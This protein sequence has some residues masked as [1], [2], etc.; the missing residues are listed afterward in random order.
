MPRDTWHPSSL[1]AMHPLSPQVC[2]GGSSWVELAASTASRPSVDQGQRGSTDITSWVA[3][4]PNSCCQGHTAS[5]PYLPPDLPLAC[6]LSP[7]I[8]SSPLSQCS[9]PVWGPL[10]PRFPLNTP[11][12]GLLC[13]PILCLLVLQCTDPGPAVC[14]TR[15]P[16]RAYTPLASAAAH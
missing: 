12:S 7:C 14:S 8:P 2:S 10:Y 3:R 4:Y 16:M 1:L 11:R 15:A 6:I 9:A 5:S 13:G